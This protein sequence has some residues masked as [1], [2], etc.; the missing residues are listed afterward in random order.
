MTSRYTIRNPLF[1]GFLAMV[2]G[3]VI[4]CLADI[5]AILPIVLTII[6]LAITHVLIKKRLFCLSTL[7]LLIG[8]WGMGW[9]LSAVHEHYLP[10]R[11]LALCPPS[12]EVACVGKCIE[13]PD[14]HS[15]H[16]KLVVECQGIETG[17][18][19][20]ERSD[21]KLQLSISDSEPD[22]KRLHSL[23]YGDIVRIETKLERPTGYGNPGC[24]QPDDYLSVHDIFLTG[25]VKYME[26]FDVLKPGTPI[27]FKY[28]L[29]E[30][31]KRLMNLIWKHGNPFFQEFFEKFDVSEVEI[32]GLSQAILLGGRESLH[33][34]IKLDF[35]KSGL[36]HILAI[37]GLHVGIVFALV[38]WF[39]GWIVP[40]IRLRSAVS[41]LCLLFYC[42]V[43]GASASVV[44]ATLLICFY[45]LAKILKRETRILNLLGFTAILLL[46]VN[47]KSLFDIGFQ[48]TFTA[49]FGIVLLSPVFY[50]PFRGF[51]Y[52]KLF[53]L[54][55]V[56][57]AAQITTAP[58]SAY[59]FNRIG[60]LAFL[61][62]L[63]LVPLI[64]VALFTGLTGLALFSTGYL[65]I[66]LIR[67][68][69]S[70]IGLL[71]VFSQKISSLPGITVTIRTPDL[72]TIALWTGALL[73]LISW[74]CR[75]VGSLTTAVVMLMLA[76][77]W[78]SYR[79]SF[80]YKDKL[81]IYVMDVGNGDSTLIRTP[82]G[83]YFLVDAGGIYN[84]DFDIGRQIVCRTLLTLNVDR[85]RTAVIT[86][87]HPDHQKGM[88]AI[89]D[90]FPVE[91]LWVPSQRFDDADF[92]GL[93][94]RAAELGIPL[95]TLDT[96]RIYETV[97]VGYNNRSLVLGLRYGRFSLLLPGDAEKEAEAGLLRYGC[98]LNMFALKAGHHGSRSS[99][100]KAFLDTVKPAVIMIPSGR[101]NQF[102]HPH[103][104]TIDRMR[105]LQPPPIIYRSDLNG[106]IHLETDGTQMTLKT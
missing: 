7:T 95:K 12:E 76:M 48:L 67:V 32:K 54:L 49:T 88:Y 26:F 10:A 40:D 33:D 29:C 102:G 89:L 11:H 63:F 80:H 14:I 1:L 41:M 56:S 59:Y 5:T 44:R 43:T 8:F 57:I 84:S 69:A 9:S 34:D 68:H 6:I 105:S 71:I 24:F 97:D 22:L 23:K 82:G 60:G 3:I 66:L 28:W 37:S 106:M 18:G 19:I 98:A 78:H 93:M 81:N 42:V 2:P 62:Y 96:N 25:S 31:R 75:P 101:N 104:E 46:A 45:L 65:G 15:A 38:Y 4:G 27:S 36:F 92:S 17:A 94:A 74:K 99:S 51:R 87:P 103:Q 73:V 20:M 39:L 16:P 30:I 50:H 55:A 58:L 85:I 91:E 61:P 100:S 77:M 13:L 47:P 83:E 90:T 35:Q 72:L 53:Q 52:K 86:H 21:G 70:C 64:T 79:A